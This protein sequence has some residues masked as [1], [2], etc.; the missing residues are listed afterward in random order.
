MTVV[1]SGD[2]RCLFGRRDS[3]PFAAGGRVGLGN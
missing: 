1:Y 2:V 3:A